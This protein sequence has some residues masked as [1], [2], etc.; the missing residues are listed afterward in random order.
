MVPFYEVASFDVYGH[1]TACK[2]A[3]LVCSVLNI[4]TS[5]V[6]ILHPIKRT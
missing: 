5:L 4:E 3:E 1:I 6:I 2:K